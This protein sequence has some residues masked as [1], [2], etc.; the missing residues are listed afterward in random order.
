MQYHVKAHT[1]DEYGYAE[2]HITYQKFA[3]VEQAFQ[4]VAK[5]LQEDYDCDTLGEMHYTIEP[6]AEVV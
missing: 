4:L 3:S 6:V 5:L 1:F 2:G